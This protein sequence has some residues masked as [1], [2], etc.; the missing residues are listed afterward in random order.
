MLSYTQGQ[1]F[2]LFFVAG[3]CIGLIYDIFRVL[4]KNF[5]TSDLITQI[6]DV[7]FLVFSGFLV[8][9]SILKFNNGEVRFYLFMAIFLGILL[10]FL[11][12]SKPYVI[13]LN[14]IVKFCKKILSFF[15]NFV[16]IPYTFIKN[17]IK[18][19]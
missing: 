2:I 7:I 1:I 19:L 16:K 9:Y 11:T 4:R 14:I 10:Y 5:H 3:I 13:I 15:V 12:I 6:E 18:K 8:L 17:H